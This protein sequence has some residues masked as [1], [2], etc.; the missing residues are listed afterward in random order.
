MPLIDGDPALFDHAGNDAGFRGTRADRAH[1]AITALGDSIDLRTHFSGGEKRVPPTV[2][3]RASRVRSLAT[4]RDGVTL[5]PESSQDCTQRQIEVEQNGP[6]FDVQF[7]V[8]CGVLK[9]F[10]AFFH[11]VELDT[12]SS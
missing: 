4:K 9:F 2:H 3:G 10:A 11:S 6:L 1:S 7:K 5:N 8:R 12:D